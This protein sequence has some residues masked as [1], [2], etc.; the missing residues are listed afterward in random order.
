MESVTPTQVCTRGPN[1]VSIV[2]L[3]QTIT[4]LPESTLTGPLRCLQREDE[5]T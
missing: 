4:G 3:L 2:G 5:W 1:D